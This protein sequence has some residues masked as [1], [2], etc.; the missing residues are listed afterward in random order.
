MNRSVET[1]LRKLE[2]ASPDHKARMF[3]IEGQTEAERQGQVDALIRSGE[4]KPSDCFIHTGVTRSPASPHRCGP[5]D[6]LLE[7]V[8]TEGRTIH[9]PRD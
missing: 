2:A 1:R 3:I 5:V 9:E 4:A 7:R 8:A 6:D